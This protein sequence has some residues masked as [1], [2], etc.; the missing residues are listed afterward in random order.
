[1]KRK[2]K[3]KS[4]VHDLDKILSM[5][6]GKYSTMNRIHT[7]STLPPFSA[8]YASSSHLMSPILSN[9]GNVPADLDGISIHPSIRTPNHSQYRLP[10]RPNNLGIIARK[11]IATILSIFG[12]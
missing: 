11:S 2:N 9:F 4:T 10:I 3:I 8:N 1:M 12:K 5:R 7:K 6:Q